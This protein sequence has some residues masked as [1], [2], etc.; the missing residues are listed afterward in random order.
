L[1]FFRCFF[2]LLLPAALFGEGFS[3]A[4]AASLL[5]YPSLSLI[6]SFLI[7]LWFAGRYAADNLAKGQNL[8][9]VSTKY[10]VTINFV[11]WTIFYL[12]LL[13][14]ARGTGT[15][16]FFYLP[17]FSAIIGIILAPFTVGLLICL[18]IKRKITDANL[19]NEILLSDSEPPTDAEI[20]TDNSQLLLT[21]HTYIC[22][23]GKLV[24]EQKI[25]I[26]SSEDA[27]FLNGALAPSAKYKVGEKQFVL[28]SNGYVYAVRGFTDNKT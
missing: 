12:V 23:E 26:P 2:G 19:D 11:I 17:L 15:E 28:I 5:V 6:L 25:D 14:F 3:L 18:V 7:I 27:A 21:R 22:D 9:L 13:F 16:I 8:F 1:D 10:S 4:M 24:I 20:E